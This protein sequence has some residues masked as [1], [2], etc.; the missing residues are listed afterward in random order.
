MTTIIYPVSEPHYK[1]HT[2][3]FGNEVESRAKPLLLGIP[4]E[5]P[6]TIRT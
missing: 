3:T 4:L 1:M 5:T 2:H 6:N